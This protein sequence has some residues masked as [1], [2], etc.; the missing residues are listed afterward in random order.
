[1]IFIMNRLPSGSDGATPSIISISLV[2]AK[3]RVNTK[4]VYMRDRARKVQQT[5]LCRIE[6]GLSS[7]DLRLLQSVFFLFEYFQ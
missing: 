1:M 7:C 3:P 5:K 4:P 6:E 2:E